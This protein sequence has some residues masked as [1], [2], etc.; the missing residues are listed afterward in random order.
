MIYSNIQTCDIIAKAI[1][2]YQPL[3]FPPTLYMR[4]PPSDADNILQSLT[5]NI[6]NDVH[7]E[8]YIQLDSDES[9]K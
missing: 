5:L 2:R 7:C 4:E 6:L 3:F 9:C 1:D 8:S